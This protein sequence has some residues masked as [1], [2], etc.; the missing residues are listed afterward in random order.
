ML[1]EGWPK[2]EWAQT[3]APLLTGEA[4]LTYYTFPPASA[5]DYML[6]KKE[7]LVWCGLSSCQAAAEFHCWTYK[8][9]LMLQSQMDRLL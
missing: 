4:Q 6:L 9:N 1:H 2:E 3:M 7:V 8:V 5:G